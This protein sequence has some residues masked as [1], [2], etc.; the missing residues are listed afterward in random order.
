MRPGSGWIAFGALLI[1][2]AL[3]S[4]A[5]QLTVSLWVGGQRGLALPVGLAAAGGLAMLVG[6][7]I[8]ANRK[9]GQ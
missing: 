1:L 7:T 5:L 6:V 2:W 8:G 4:V 3:T 9:G